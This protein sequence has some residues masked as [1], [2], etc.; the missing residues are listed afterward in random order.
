M[1]EAQVLVTVDRLRERAASV[2]MRVALD[3][4]WLRHARLA[5]QLELDNE[6]EVLLE[7]Q[8]RVG[9]KYPHKLED[10][11]SLSADSVAR[12]PSGETWRPRPWR[13][14]AA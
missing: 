9:W 3:E 4:A 8:R 13:R 2:G 5:P 6:R 1:N 10:E 12:L 11:T 7:A 14:R